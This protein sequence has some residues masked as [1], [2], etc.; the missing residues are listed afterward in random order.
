MIRVVAYVTIYILDPYTTS[1]VDGQYVMSAVTTVVVHIS[2]SPVD[3]IKTELVVDVLD[4][5]FNQELPPP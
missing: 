2:T 1:V 5:V 4:V 3:S